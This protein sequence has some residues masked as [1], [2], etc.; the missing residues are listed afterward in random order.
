MSPDGRTKSQIDHT[1]I[2]KRYRSN[3]RQVRSYQGAGRD[4]DHYL[5]IASFRNK[6]ANSWK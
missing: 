5:V 3:I 6:L 4:T 2:D 1:L